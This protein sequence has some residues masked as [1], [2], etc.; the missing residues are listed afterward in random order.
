MKICLVNNLYPPYASGGTEAVVKQTIDL[1]ITAGHQVVLITTQPSQPSNQ[2][3]TIEHSSDATIY[4]FRPKNIY[5]YTDGMKQPVWKKLAWHAIDMINP[6][7]A[8]TL[9]KILIREKP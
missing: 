7:D 9:R 6:A 4:R 3:W 8:S 5:Y 1:L 2:D